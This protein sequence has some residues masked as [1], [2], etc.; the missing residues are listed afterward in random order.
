LRKTRTYSPSAL[1]FADLDRNLP[2][3]RFSASYQPPNHVLDVLQ[4]I[5]FEEALELDDPRYVDPQEARGSQR[6]LDRPA[7]KFGLL[8]ADGRFAP[9]TQ[10]HVLFFGHTGSGKTTE[11]RRY[12]HRLAGPKSLFLSSRSASH[13]RSTGTISSMQMP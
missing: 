10:K 8:L 1:E 4:Q 5:E 6:T 3:P 9:T 13:R 7:R 12:A 2:G 11:L